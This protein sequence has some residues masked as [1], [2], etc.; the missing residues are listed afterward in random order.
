M[1][2]SSASGL[3]F[4]GMIATLGPLAAAGS[5]IG[6]LPHGLK[7]FVLLIGPIFVPFGNFIIGFLSDIIG[8]KKIFIITMIMYGAGIVVIALSYTF[9]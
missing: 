5:L 2:L 7:V 4:W 3:T 1:L 8:R 9:V 6:T